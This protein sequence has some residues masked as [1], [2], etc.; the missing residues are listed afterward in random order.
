M[1]GVGVLEEIL[2]SDTANE[3]SRYSLVMHA[4]QTKW[5]A[6]ADKRIIWVF[7]ATH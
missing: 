1:V 3:E 6:V 7:V 2:A 4:C 5:S